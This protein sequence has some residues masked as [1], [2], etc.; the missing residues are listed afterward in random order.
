[1][2][3]E[4]FRALLIEA[5]NGEAEVISD[6]LLE[7][8][9]CKLDRLA[10]AN[11]A[12]EWLSRIDYHLV[13]IAAD[14]DGAAGL[15][16]T[17]ERVK[18]AR[19]RSAVLVVSSHASIEQAV[20]SMRVGADD[21]LARPCDPALFKTAAKR[22][23][24]RRAAYGPATDSGGML[25]L[26]MT[27]QLISASVE[28]NHV[29]GLISGYVGRATV[30]DF[31]EV[32][33]STPQGPVIVE[34]ADAPELQGKAQTLSEVLSI[35]LQTTTPFSGWTTNET[36]FRL[37]EKG[38]LTPALFVYRFEFV[39][40]GEYFICGLSPRVGSGLSEVESRLRLLH[41]QIDATVRNIERY[42]GIQRLAYV[43]DATGLYNTRYLNDLL[44]REIEQA[45]QIKRSFAVLFMDVDR[46]KLVNDSHGHLVGTKI[47][48]EMG[49][50]L[51]KYVRDTDTVFRY[52]G[53]EFIAVLSPSDLKTALAVAERIRASI[54]KYVFLKSEGL[55]IKLTLSI[56]VALF[57]DH[58]SSKRAIMDAADH[59]M[60][61]VKRS[62][63]NA[64]YT[65]ESAAASA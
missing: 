27:C 49:A 26:M 58:A 62:S 16:D 40:G 50:Q 15:S 59:A 45:R 38:Q 22:A 56:G 7:V 63:R 29:L 5:D 6:L 20:A 11:N 39:G 65:A 41:A 54:E 51:Q 24:A 55:N 52:G 36:S 33:C 4:T 17:L 37:I 32:Y 61:T 30:S 28:D 19:P 10:D 25:A 34:T 9:D 64:V 43:D 48:Y 42:R 44:A 13:I 31:C 23:L 21:F 53:D 18:R 57:P 60:Y 3:R 12:V 46:F 1:M 35:A 8:G 14:V 47:L 2:S